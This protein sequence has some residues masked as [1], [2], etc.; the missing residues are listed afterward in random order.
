M[1]KLVKRIKGLPEVSKNTYAVLGWYLLE[2]VLLFA[3]TVLITFV[4]RPIALK[5]AP[6]WHVALIN[7]AAPIF[8]IGITGVCLFGATLTVTALITRKDISKLF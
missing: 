3:T 6:D 8:T 4:L 2:F 1:K 7:V 5:T